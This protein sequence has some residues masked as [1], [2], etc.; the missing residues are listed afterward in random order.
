MKCAK[1]FDFTIEVDNFNFNVNCNIDD[2]KK[3][4]IELSITNNINNNIIIEKYKGIGDSYDLAISVL[5]KQIKNNYHSPDKI[6]IYNEAINKIYLTLL[7]NGMILE[8]NKNNVLIAETYGFETIQVKNKNNKYVPKVVHRHNNILLNAVYL[9]IESKDKKHIVLY[10]KSSKLN[11]VF[12][13]SNIILDITERR[14]LVKETSSSVTNVIDLINENIKLGKQLIETSPDYIKHLVELTDMNIY[15]NKNYIT[16]VSKY[17][18]L[19]INEDSKAI[20][21][22]YNSVL[23]ANLLGIKINIFIKD[24]TI[25]GLINNITNIIYNSLQ[26]ESIVSIP[27]VYNKCLANFDQEILMCKIGKMLIENWYKNDFKGI[28][29]EN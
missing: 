26:N 17:I 28:K 23:K 13:T 18:T 3:Y 4:I 11:N 29:Y 2:N 24:K 14:A 27:K 15:Y 25:F 20:E 9:H 1:D 8:I 12:I 6:I 22:K 10:R 19:I 16:Y 21:N 7:K 5:Q